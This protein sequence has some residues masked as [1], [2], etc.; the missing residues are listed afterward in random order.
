METEAKFGD[1]MKEAGTDKG[2]GDDGQV[3]KRRDPY[4]DCLDSYPTSK[5]KTGPGPPSKINRSGSDLR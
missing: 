1:A 2:Q 4:G 5:I 3:E